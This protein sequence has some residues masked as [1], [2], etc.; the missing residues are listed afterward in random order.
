LLLRKNR[1]VVVKEK[2]SNSVAETRIP[3]LSLQFRDLRKTVGPDDC[4][5]SRLIISLQQ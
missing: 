3:W 1:Q 4:M 2:P 5:P